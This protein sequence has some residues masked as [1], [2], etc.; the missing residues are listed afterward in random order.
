MK[1]RKFI[2]LKSDEDLT[3]ALNHILER[4]YALEDK[5]SEM[6]TDLDHMTDLIAGEAAGTDY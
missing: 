4:V 2:D 1:I 5:L 6:D 3:K